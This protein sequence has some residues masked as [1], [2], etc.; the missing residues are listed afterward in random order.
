MG[1][2]ESKLASL[3]SLRKWHEATK[4]VGKPAESVGKQ[5][6]VSAKSIASKPAVSGKD[7]AKS[8]ASKPAVSGQV[9][10]KSI[11]SKPALSGQV[12]TNSSAS[13]PATSGQGDQESSASKPAKSAQESA[14]QPEESGNETESIVSQPEESGD[15]TESSASQQESTDNI[16][17][18]GCIN[19]DE[20]TR[21]DLPEDDDESRQKVFE[22]SEAVEEIVQGIQGIQGL[23][24]AG[25]SASDVDV[26]DPLCH[27]ENIGIMLQ[28]YYALCI[29]LGRQDLIPFANLMKIDGNVETGTDDDREREKTVICVD[30]LLKKYGKDDFSETVLK[31]FKKAT[32][33]LPVNGLLDN[34]REKSKGKP[35]GHC[36]IQLFNKVLKYVNVVLKTVCEFSCL[37]DPEEDSSGLGPSIDPIDID[38]GVDDDDDGDDDFF[39]GGYSQPVKTIRF[40]L[41]GQCLSPNPCAIRF[42]LLAR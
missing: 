7:D 13:K 15:D 3:A 38:L 30:N 4:P 36:I 32:T 6:Q 33:E 41:R 29:L 1:S 24:R 9:T 42:F 35:Y 14:S 17:I 23:A 5:G 31:E 39:Y 21:D 25:E 16:V 40:F 2:S 18:D 19:N 26:L 34:L 10:A 37:P 22:L 8:I 20:I 12:S 28:I 11:A 27:A